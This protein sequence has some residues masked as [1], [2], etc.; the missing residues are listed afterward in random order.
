M[1]RRLDHRSYEVDTG[2]TIYRR[3]RAHLRSSH[4][5]PPSEDKGPIS[6]TFNPTLFLTQSATVETKRTQMWHK[7]RQGPQPRTS[8]E[9][10]WKDYRE[11]V[12]YKFTQ[13]GEKTLR[14]AVRLNPNHKKR[15][16]KVGPTWIILGQEEQLSDQIASKTLWVVCSWRKKKKKKKP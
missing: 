9:G 16:M 14:W 7:H 2:G 5:P 12:R 3:N 4:E 11:A 15:T 6:P 13:K 10:P 1:A 8:L